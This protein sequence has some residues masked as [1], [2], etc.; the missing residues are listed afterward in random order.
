MAIEIVKRAS[1]L[2]NELILYLYDFDKVEERNLFS[3]AFGPKDIGQLKAEAVGGAVSHYPGV[4]VIVRPWKVTQDRIPEMELNERSIVIDAVDNLEARHLLWG[5]GVTKTCPVLHMGM[6]HGG[7]G[8][9][10]W[11]WSEYDLF[12]L[13]PPNMTPE[14]LQEHL[15]NL[16]NGVVP[17]EVK[18]PPCDL[19]SARALA[20]NTV[21][22][23]V[24][25]LWIFLGEDVSDALPEDLAAFKKAGGVMTN[26]ETSGLQ[27]NI[28]LHSKEC[29]GVCEPWLI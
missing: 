27:R 8:T 4:E 9:V 18:L 12:P 22:S 28:Q 13:S 7:S 25:A 21:Y 19:N 15:E 17:K 10:N 24:D 23:A 29:L 6:S 20:L 26:W 5:L 1:A 16:K 3:Q 14:V 11:N 2:G